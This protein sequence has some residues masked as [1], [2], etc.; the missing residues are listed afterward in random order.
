MLAKL[1]LFLVL[2]VH[3]VRRWTMQMILL[4][5]VLFASFVLHLIFY[6]SFVNRRYIY[7]WNSE[8]YYD[9]NEPVMSLAVSPISKDSGGQ[10][11]HFF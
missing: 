1:L 10:V 5:A 2:I 7:R 8:I 11:Y 9:F 4:S 3:Q 6:F